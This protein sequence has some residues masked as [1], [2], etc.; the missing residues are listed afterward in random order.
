MSAAPVLIAPLPQHR[1]DE[2]RLFAWLAGRLPGF[3]GPAELRQFQGGQSNPTYLITT[4]ERRYVLRKKPPGKLLPSAHQ[5]ERE[6]RVLRALDGTA[7]PVPP[8]RVLCEDEGV[9]GTAFYVM[10]FVDGRVLTDTTLAALE[11]DERRPIYDAMAQTLAALHRVDYRTAGLADFGKPENFVG[12][13]INLWTKQYL[14]AKTDELPAMDALMRWLPENAPATEEVTVVHG[15]FR[16]GNLLYAHDGPQVLA[17]LDWELATLGHPLSDL[18]YVALPYH[19][20]PGGPLPGLRELDAA[21]WG[22]PSEAEFLQAYARAV[23]REDI[24]DWP[25]FLAL[26]LFRL[27]GITQGVYARALQGNA[28]DGGAMAMAAVARSAAEIGW[29]IAS[30][31]RRVA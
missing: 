20:P 19:L 11:K 23:G 25:F 10:D 6:Y 3:A 15:D 18:A 26:S 28:A 29:E 4:P 16:L 9:I 24:P 5:I 1:L 17:V 12:R 14:A 30:G 8:A 2:P 22:L 13:Q 7:V 31:A 27:A 21:A